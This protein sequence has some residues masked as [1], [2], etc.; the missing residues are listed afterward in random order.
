MAKY[1]ALR[2]FGYKDINAKAGDI[3]DLDKE[4]VVALGEGI[5]A[6]SRKAKEDKG[7]E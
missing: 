5:V 4:T 2:D 7:E 6:S 1:K 3:V